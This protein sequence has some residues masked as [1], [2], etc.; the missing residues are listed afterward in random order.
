[1]G[2][3]KFRKRWA[4]TRPTKE[5]LTFLGL[6][7]FVGFA[8]L[9]TGN[10]LLY[11]VFGMMLSFIAASGIISTVNLAKLRVRFEP[12]SDV[13]ALSPT[14]FKFNVANLKTYLPSYSL[15]IAVDGRKT[16]IPYLPPKTSKTALL[17]YLFKRRGVSRISDVELYT[18][19]PFGFFK[20]VVSVELGEDENI[21][22]Y[23]KIESISAES[24]DFE[25]KFGET[26]SE[27]LGFGS[28]LRSIRLYKDGDNP[29]LIHWRTTAKYG[30]MFLRELDED[31][32][33]SVIV[34]F[35]PP[36]DKAGLEREIVRTASVLVDLAGRGFEVEFVAPGE[37]FAPAQPGRFPRPALRYLA[38][39]GS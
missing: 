38:L 15:T 23:P 19:F 34:E 31:E 9:N 39:F 4:D 16:Y 25:S 26:E 30:K 28:D 11:L 27:R 3:F 20:K 18:R 5:G 33:K 29:K 22:V 7:L 32:S 13:F 12:P 1:M 24:D 14:V 35:T 6:T 17:E 21:L 36:R 2:L 10:N 37:A 8:A